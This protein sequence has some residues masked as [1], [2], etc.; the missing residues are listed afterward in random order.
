MSTLCGFN[1]QQEKFSL[2]NFSEFCSQNF[3]LQVKTFVNELTKFID[4]K[5]HLQFGIRHIAQS[6]KCHSNYPH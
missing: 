1:K 6:F 2:K 5:I 4:N 3:I